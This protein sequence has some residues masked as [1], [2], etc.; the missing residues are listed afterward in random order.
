[1][2]FISQLNIRILLFRNL[3]F[4]CAGLSAGRRRGFH[5]SH[6]TDKSFNKLPVS[7]RIG[8]RRDTHH[9]HLSPEQLAIQANYL[10][11]PSPQKVPLDDTMFEA[12]HNQRHPA[13]KSG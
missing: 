3:S 2:T 8:F 13:G 12:R 6:K 7:K 5:L 1:M 9:Q 11:Q 4:I 10:L